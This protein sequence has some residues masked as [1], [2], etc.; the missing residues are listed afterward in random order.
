VF[1]IFKRKRTF[2]FLF[3]F[4]VSCKPY[5]FDTGVHSALDLGS[6]TEQDNED[7]TEKNIPLSWEKTIAEGTNW[8]QTIYRVIQ[9][10]EPQL[11]LDDGI[12]DVE[13]FC[14]RYSALTKTQKLNFWGQLIA[15]IAY[16]ESRWN[17]VA[18]YVETSMGQ[19]PVTQEPVV[20]EGL[21][22]LS[23]QDVPNH[24][25]I[26]DFNWLKD[27]PLNKINPFDPRK[28]ILNPAKNLRCGMRILAEQIRKKRAIAIDAGA[29]WAVLKVNSSHQRIE[30]IA[31]MTK[32][33]G[34]CN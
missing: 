5:S 3:L 16:Y 9:A 7:T 8:S 13:F 12:N 25:N 4:V 11:L 34:F 23:Y 2:L 21:L 32:S 18:R 26:C 20:S 24:N 27:K 17:P 10:E 31:D 15:A 6:N 28:T 19:D 14:P 33:L 30:A 29:Y 1:V 22:Q